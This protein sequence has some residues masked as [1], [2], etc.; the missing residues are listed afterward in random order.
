MSKLEQH[1]GPRDGL[2][3]NGATRKS[4]RRKLCVLA[5]SLVGLGLWAGSGHAGQQTWTGGAS[6]IWDTL[7]GN[8]G[9]TGTITLWDTINGP[10]NVAVFNTSSALVTVSGTPATVYANG[11]TFNSPATIS[12]N[13][14][15]LAGTTPTITTNADAMIGSSISGSAG[16]IKSGTGRLKLI[17]S[18]PPGGTSPSG[19]NTYTGGTVVNGGRLSFIAETGL[20][21]V[22]A[23]TESM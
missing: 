19:A 12:G 5:A 8:W 9:G 21:A 17:G 10:T 7:D 20:G 15:T 18:N 3:I 22:P 6:G 1:P 14:L 13:T 2:N 23:S 16:L 11:I 4:A